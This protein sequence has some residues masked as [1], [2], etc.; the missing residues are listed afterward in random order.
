MNKARRRKQPILP[1]AALGLCA[2]PFALPIVLTFALA[3]S[4]GET[5]PRNIAPGSGLKLAGLVI[6]A[7]TAAAVWQW[8]TRRLES[9]PARKFAGLLCAATALLGWPAW[10]AGVLPSVN[11]ME[12]GPEHDVQMRLVRLETTR[13]GRGTPDL[14]HW[15][16]IEPLR[17][18]SPIAGGRV[19]IP[20]DIHV[21]WH[22]DRP[23]TVRLRHAEGLLGAEV[24]TAF[25]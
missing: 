6:T 22:A 12:I 3:I 10:G 17:E 5:W 2:L 23:A 9:A 15:A 20:E 24:V 8:A 11:G 14:Y 4:I 19:P 1:P 7:V 13:R 18:R 16:W 25:D 21:R